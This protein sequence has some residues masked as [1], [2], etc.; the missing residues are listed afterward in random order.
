MCGRCFRYTI[1]SKGFSR[2]LLLFKVND[3]CDCVSFVFL[4]IFQW[5]STGLNGLKDFFRQT[6]A[7]AKSFLIEFDTSASVDEYD[8]FDAYFVLLMVVESSLRERPFV[9]KSTSR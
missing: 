6:C 5:T 8:W 2:S 7:S 3:T 9:E 1:D 4:A